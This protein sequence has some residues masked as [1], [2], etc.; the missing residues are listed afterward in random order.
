MP[1]AGDAPPGSASHL[2]TPQSDAASFDALAQDGPAARGF[3][4]AGWF[5]AP[6]QGAIDRFVLRD[7]KGRPQA[8]LALAE[9][10]KGPLRLREVA[11]PYWPFRGIPLAADVSPE[12]LAPL[13]R[14]QAPRFGR[15]WRMGPVLA[16]CGQSATLVAAARLAGWRVL[17]R[18][19]GQA[20]IVDLAALKARGNW[21]STKGA[22]K[23]RWRVRQ[24]AKQGPV[25]IRFYTGTDWSAA[26]RDA[27]AAI[28]ARSWVGQLERGGDTKFHD[29]AL[30]ACWEE[31]ARDP[32]LAAMI[33]GMLLFVGERPVAFT[34]GLDCGTT[35]YCIANNYDRDFA[36]HSPGRVLLYA[37]FEAAHA[38]GIER[39][40]WG[41]GD[42]GYKS[43]MGA[44]P[45]PAMH[46]LL[47]VR[48]PVLPAL[49]RRWWERPA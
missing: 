46:D 27:I 25:S 22:Q 9:R 17:T 13:L 21:P 36:R 2:H 33:R 31:A 26:D 42:A 39:I 10:R 5:A 1:D 37:D 49:L 30:R 20:F 47:F 24:M 12:A 23:D 28:E 40:D 4:R 7:Q 48:A 34:F 14:A 32:A 44:A 41:L 29:P 43:D 16:D 18:A 11:G 35:R 38:R 15:V 8:A 3:L 19:V 6:P 45:G